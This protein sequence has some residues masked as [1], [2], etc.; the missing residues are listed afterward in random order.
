ML[1]NKL[2]QIIPILLQCASHIRLRAIRLIEKNRSNQA[3]R[4]P[5]WGLKS[6]RRDTAESAWSARDTI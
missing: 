1:A 4:R 5:H 6:W 3:P 2:Q